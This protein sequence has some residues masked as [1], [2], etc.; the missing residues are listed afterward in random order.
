[1]QAQVTQLDGVQT[2]IR[3]FRPWYDTSFQSLTML[4]K[5]TECFPE[6]GSVTAKSIEV[7][8]DTKTNVPVTTI[9]ISG[10]ARDKASALRAIDQIR[11]LREVSDQ[12]TEQIRTPTNGPAQYTFTFRW[13]SGAG[14]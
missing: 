6:N 3:E 14:S 13:N 5:I 1:M 7:H 8:T 12:K 2:R 10:I 9:T 11:K 4:K